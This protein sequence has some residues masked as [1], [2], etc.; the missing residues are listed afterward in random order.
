MAVPE[1]IRTLLS[2]W[3]AAA[4]P[5]A[6]RE[7][8]QIGYTTQGDDVTILDRRP[9]AYPE[10]GVEWSATPVALLHLEDDG[11]WVLYRATADGG[12][13][14]ETAGPDPIALLEQVRG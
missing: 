9:P 8:R 13:R 4:V 14:Q 3:C 10:L 1:E 7:Q 6:E 5:D 12:W 11:G 2:Q